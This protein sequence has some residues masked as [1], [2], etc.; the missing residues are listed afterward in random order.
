MYE[1]RRDKCALLTSYNFYDQ[2]ARFWKTRLYVKI[3]NRDILVINDITNLEQSVTEK[4]GYMYNGI[5]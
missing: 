4:W 3:G 1:L 2:K 5:E